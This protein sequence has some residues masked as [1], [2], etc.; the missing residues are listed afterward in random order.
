MV[1]QA[2]PL[3]R[4]FFGART[5]EVFYLR[6]IQL[7]FEKQS[8]HWVTSR[9][10]QELVESRA[11]RQELRPLQATGEG[12]I[13]FLF[14]PSA[15]YTRRLIVRKV[16]LI[17][18]FSQEALG[19]ACGRQAEMLFSRTLMTK[20][21]RFVAEN[22]R[23]YRG[24]EWSRTGHDLDFIVERD[25]VGYGCEVKNRFEYIDSDEM[26]TKILM[27]QH[28]GIRPPFIV[29][30]APNSYIYE[31][32]IAQVSRRFLRVDGVGA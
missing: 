19:R 14:H 4:E 16:G 11:V 32:Q 12:Q 8:Y 3:L 20:G 2:I 9:A 31:A 10:L 7:L 25:G 13:N 1:V 18:R 23:A 6:Q 28:L 30:G 22:A 21:F 26:R 27:C 17:R 29:R 15:R 24:V 5:T